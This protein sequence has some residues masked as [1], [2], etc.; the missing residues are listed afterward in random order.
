MSQVNFFMTLS[1]E[2]SFLDF[3]FARN[4][5]HLLGGCFFDSRKPTPIGSKAATRNVPEIT[6]VNKLIM[7]EPK[8]GK[9]GSGDFTGKYTFDL[10]CDPIIHFS[11]SRLR[12]KR[13]VNGRIYAKIGR[14]K[15]MEANAVYK[16]WYA[17]I[18]RWLKK[19]YRV[20]NK[21]WWFGPEAW[22]WS[23]AGG[24]CCF[25]GELAFARSLA[26]IDSTRTKP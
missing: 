26:N 5:T 9:R 10:L 15:P 18:E 6:L 2:D 21:T 13:L 7:A 14:L 3:L 19:H 24:V 8:A 20:I 16:S 4:D 17:S 23:K 22:D 12:K 1:D 25:G 11:R